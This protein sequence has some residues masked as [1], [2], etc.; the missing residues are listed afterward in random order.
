MDDNKNSRVTQLLYKYTKKDVILPLPQSSE[1]MNST[2][3]IIRIPTYQS[4]DVSLIRTLV[5][6]N[7]CLGQVKQIYPFSYIS[8][9]YSNYS[10]YYTLYLV[11]FNVVY[12]MTETFNSMS[13]NI[14]YWGYH[15]VTVLFDPTNIYASN[16]LVKVYFDNKICNIMNEPTST[17]STP[18][19]TS[20]ATKRKEKPTSS[21][22]AE[23][24]KVKYE[25]LRLHV[26]DAFKRIDLFEEKN[27]ELKEKNRQLEES[28]RKL[29]EQNREF[30]EKTKKMEENAKELKDSVSW[31]HKIFYNKLRE[32]KHDLYDDIYNDIM[33]KINEKEE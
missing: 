3:F 6:T 27:Q 10:N 2:V 13:Q 30:E 7:M 17:A 5:E 23:D 9:N 1:I 4:V 15:D 32:I 16:V 18:A 11:E 26:S 28:V 33:D 31:M 14:Q 21:E 22:K 24:I 12:T 29:E 8:D 20:H 19:A 25:S